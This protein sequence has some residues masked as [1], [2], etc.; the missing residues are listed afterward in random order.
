MYTLT[1]TVHRLS[2]RPG[3]PA[4]DKTRNKDN[5][6]EEEQDPRHGH[7][8][9]NDEGYLPLHLQDRLDGP[10]LGARRRSAWKKERDWPLG[11]HAFDALLTEEMLGGPPTEVAVDEGQVDG[12]QDAAH[13]CQDGQQAVSGR[14]GRVRR[15]LV[16]FLY[17]GNGFACV[18]GQC[19]KE[20]RKKKKT[21]LVAERQW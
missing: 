17:L 12:E 19:E 7:S 15:P 14:R 21:G 9:N 3:T 4:L 2:A 18:A 5:V 13:H 20:G 16:R 11:W 8:H 6:E 10:G 1:P